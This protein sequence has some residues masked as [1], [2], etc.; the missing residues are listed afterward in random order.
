MTIDRKRE[1][2]LKAELI[3]V[4]PRVPNDKASLAHAQSKDVQDL[5]IDYLNWRSRY[6]AKR[7][8]TVDISPEV[9]ADPRYTAEVVRVTTFL[10]KVK[11]GDDLTPHL[12]ILPHT[13]GVA[14]ASQAPMATAEDLWSDKDLI[15]NVMGF[16]HF[17]LEVAGQGTKADHD[18]MLF[19][20]ASREAF[21]AIALFDHSVFEAGTAE[22]SRLHD[23]HEFAITGGVPG[24]Y[25]MS[26][27]ATSG[28]ALVVVRYAQKCTSIME[29]YD[30]K[31]DDQ[32]Y[33]AD[34]FKQAGVAQ[35]KRAALCWN[36]LDLDLALYEK[37][38]NQAW[39]M[40][41]GWN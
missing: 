41:K 39:V 21:R 25:V 38:T 11:R 8:R 3:K 35:P 33:V 36:F 27:V 12:S 14:L 4:V 28:H 20:Q 19:A 7:A 13:R 15:L 29:E 37:T 18:M 31:L 32:A 5:M 34:L 17:H 16:H 10:D 9:M 6:V 22:R 2:Q 30:P 23:A 40:L 26:N 1:A 24:T